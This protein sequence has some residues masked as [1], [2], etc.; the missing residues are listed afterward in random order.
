MSNRQEINMRV[1][2]GAEK[3]LLVK[4]FVCIIDILLHLDYIS[5]TGLKEWRRERFAFFESIIKANPRDV[6]FALECFY[7]WVKTKNLTVSL[8]VYRSVGS[9]NKIELRFSKSGNQK[10]EDEYRTH[11]VAT[12]LND[13]KKEKR[14]KEKLNQD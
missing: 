7:R 3:A 9:A 11:Y 10:I 4:K 8:S 6:K 13:E 2:K 12:E 5:D 14:V 1:I